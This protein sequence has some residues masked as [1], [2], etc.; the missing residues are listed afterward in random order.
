M[1]AD[2]QRVLVIGLDSATFDLIDPWAAAGRLPNLARLM[3]HGCRGR[4]AST[5]QPTTAPA[6]T[7][8]LT[9]VNQGR[10]GLYDFIRRKPGDYNLE[11][12]NAGHVHA[13]GLLEIA[14]Q[15]GRRV[16]AV[17][18]P[19]TFPPRPVNG[20]VV[21]GPFA[22]AVLPEL[23]YPSAFFPTLQRL[24]PD[25]FILPDYA[26]LH[27][28]PL[29]D[30]AA[31]MLQEVELRERVSLHLLEQE[32][33]D[34]FMVVFMATDE[35]QHAFWHCMDAAPQ[36]PASRYRDAILHVYQRCDRAIGALIE[37]FTRAGEEPLVFIVSDHGAGPMRWIINLNRWLA[38]QGY[39]QY[40]PE[41]QGRAG[42]WRSAV[43]KRLARAYRRFL[44]ARLRAR[45]RAGLGA[46]RFERIKGEMESL[47]LTAVVDWERTQAYALGAGGN[48]FLNVQ[49]RE[50]QGCVPPGADYERLR[51]ELAEKLLTLADPL[52]GASIVRRV[53]RREDLYH[54]PFLEQAPD[55]VIE[56]IDYGTWGRG[57]YD[58]LAPLFEAH[59]RL[60]FS[61][62]P[63]TGSHHPQ[64]ILIAHGPGVRCGEVLEGAR[65]VDMA[66]T[67]LRLLGAAPAETLDGSL[68]EGLFEDPA[69]L[70]APQAGPQQGAQAAGAYQLTPEEEQKIAEHLKSL[71][72]L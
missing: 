36:D 69:G 16:A 31:K 1:S 42:Q 2:R 63:L 18:I 53:H 71:G 49:G 65:L 64:G 21:G 70:P 46:R 32:A 5:L 10:H 34:F 20:V 45:L 19:Y 62:L 66:P 41:R 61:E 33:W 24:A 28:D 57:R 30:Y 40:L 43:I 3:A 25:Y 48:I 27:P 23:V 67:L 7:T 12:T 47:L 22:P 39:L 35:V 11:V 9:G 58:S 60:E 44:P 56:W 26:P 59:N 6:W 13:P 55:L 52:S 14:S 68:L 54:G 15:A 51:S 17:N 37:K 8:F 4:L 72:Y 29:G 50:P 38:E